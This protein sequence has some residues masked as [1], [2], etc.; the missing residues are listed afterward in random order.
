MMDERNNMEFSFQTVIYVHPLHSLRTP[1][2]QIKK[3]P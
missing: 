2:I 3:T 1:Y